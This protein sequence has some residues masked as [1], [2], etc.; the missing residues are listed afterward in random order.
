MEYRIYKIINIIND[1]IYVGFTGFID[2]RFAQHKRESRK[3]PHRPLYQAMNE[4]GVDKFS[5][6]LIEVWECEIDMIFE[7]EQ[8]WIEHL[9]SMYPYGYNAD[10]TSLKRL[11][12]RGKIAL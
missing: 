8:Y 4:Y 9:N 10:Q 7:R 6:E 3:Y 5:I 11:R 2:P 12:E 1:K